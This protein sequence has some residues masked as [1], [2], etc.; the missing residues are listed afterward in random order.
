MYGKPLLRKEP[1]SIWASHKVGGYIGLICPVPNFIEISSAVSE[2]QMDTHDLPV[3]NH[4]V[5]RNTSVSIVCVKEPDQ[6][7]YIVLSHKWVKKS[8]EEISILYCNIPGVLF[9]TSVHFHSKTQHTIVKYNQQLSKRSRTTPCLAISPLA[10]QLTL[11]T[12]AI[13][14]KVTHAN[15]V[16]NSFNRCE[17]SQYYVRFQVLTAAGMM[18]RIVFISDDGGSTHLWN[19]SR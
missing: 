5:H 18:F 11:E 10:H 1:S 6:E 13:F 19:V 7:S 9:K 8:S 3:C 16:H 2:I 4:T 14:N 15:N 17:T 12:F